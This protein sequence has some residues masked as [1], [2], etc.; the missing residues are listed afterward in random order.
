MLDNI[1]PYAGC[2]LDPVA[3]VE[4]DGR[5][6]IDFAQVEAKLPGAALLYVNSPQNPTGKVFSR[7]ELSRLNDLCVKHGVRIVSDEAYE[8]FVFGGAKHVS[9]LEFPGDHIFA[10]LHLLEIVCRDRLPH[11][12]HRL[13]QCRHHREAD[14]RRVHADRRRGAVHPEGVRRGDDV[15]ARA[16]GLAEPAAGDASRAGAT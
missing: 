9:M 2:T 16:R 7:E 11:R 4:R 10:R 1:A 15:D 3:L 6:D 14:A 12:L 5:L 8:D 13:P